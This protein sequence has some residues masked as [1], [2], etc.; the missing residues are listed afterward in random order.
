MG[1]EL[2]RNMTSRSHNLN[3]GQPPWSIDFKSGDTPLPDRV[4]FAVVGGGFTGLS[5][6]AE[7]RRLDPSKSVAVFEA[8]SVGAR[9]SGHTGGLT[10]AE[11]AAGDLPGLGD[12]LAGFSTVLKNLDVSAQIVLQGVWELDR[13]TGTKDSPICW[14]DSGQLRVAREVPG[15]TTN[16]GKLV[17][18]LAQAASRLGA[19]VFEGARV[20]QIEFGEDLILHVRGSEIRARRVLLATN[21][22]SLEL[23]GLMGHSEPKLTLAVATEPL[24][25]DKLRSLGLGSRKPFYTV[26]LPYLW[27]RLLDK[28]EI[29]FGSG[30]V[31]VD[32]WRDLASVDVRSGEA[33]QLLARLKDR[34]TRL[35]PALAGTRFSYEWGG[36]ILIADQWRPVF[37]RH[38]RSERVI[39]LGAYS[40]HGV[41]LSVH[42]GAWAAEVLLSK[43]NL[44]DWNPG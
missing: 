8:E 14:S 38:S 44:P 24:E 43:R 1:G 36:P 9:S 34:V 18:G 35:H 2:Q 3:W 32:N 33:F 26:D 20:D 25:E 13:T 27:G 4:D 15:G 39:V 12:V 42:L 31:S 22:E 29:M 41:A 30:L 37:K 10:L 5:A 6:S 40:G 17:S 23:S 7:L 21:S 19:L 11:T 16:P 28:N